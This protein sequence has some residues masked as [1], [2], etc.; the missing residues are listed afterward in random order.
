MPENR[1][2]LSKDQIALA[3]AMQIVSIS[4]EH[5]KTA[6]LSIRSNAALYYKDKT[7]TR[8]YSKLNSAVSLFFQLALVRS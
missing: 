6:S 4:A 7:Y 8:G 2:L 5:E 1:I 3:E